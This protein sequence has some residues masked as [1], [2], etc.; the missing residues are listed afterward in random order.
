[1]AARLWVLLAALTACLMRAATAGAAAS[2]IGTPG[3]DLASPEF[4]ARAAQTATTS[5][6]IAPSLSPDRRR[7]KATLTVAIDYSGGESGLPSPVR[8][9]ILGLPAGLSLNIPALR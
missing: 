8:K 9:A 1:M 6:S 7:A 4:G 3:F 5:A 2:E